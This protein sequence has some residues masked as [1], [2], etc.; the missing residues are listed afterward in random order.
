[1]RG[2]PT[3]QELAQIAAGLGAGITPEDAIARAQELWDAATRALT[4]NE[5]ADE[6]ER[7]QIEGDRLARLG[8]D[9]WDSKISLS[10][11][12]QVANKIA[13]RT[14]VVAYK[15]EKGFA[16]AMC[17]AGLTISSPVY[18]KTI[19]EF[20][21]TSEPERSIVE[22]P[23]LTSVRAVEELFKRKAE[24]RRKGDRKRKAAKKP[25]VLTNAQRKTFKKVSRKSPT[26]KRNTTVKK[27]KE[28]SD[29]RKRSRK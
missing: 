12:F 23:E 11:A 16:H 5:T 27:P 13:K 25:A 15:T 10:E 18:G 7:L 17:T 21:K 3:L 2:A 4:V 24:Q 9:L 14:N 22:I 6:L 1:M 8:L 26:T 20:V 28:A 19:E 29:K